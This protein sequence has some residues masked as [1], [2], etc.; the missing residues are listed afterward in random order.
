MSIDALKE[1]IKNNKIK[2]LY[3]FYGPEDYLK[4]YY[5]ESIEK[6]ILSEE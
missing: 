2:N 1:D 3:L 6:L 5:L 4:K